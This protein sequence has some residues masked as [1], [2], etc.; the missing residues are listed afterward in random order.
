MLFS[1]STSSF[2]ESTTTT[3]SESSQHHH[4]HRSSISIITP[5]DEVDGAPTIG[6]KQFNR[7]N[8][9]EGECGCYLNEQWMLDINKNTTCTNCAFVSPHPSPSSPSLPINGMIRISNSNESSNSTGGV[10]VSFFNCTFV[11]TSVLITNIYNQSTTGT[12]SSNDG[13]SRGTTAAGISVSFDECQFSNITNEYVIDVQISNDDNDVKTGLNLS[14]NSVC[15]FFSFSLLNSRLTDNSMTGVRLYI[16]GVSERSDVDEDD[17]EHNEDLFVSTSILVFNTSFVGNQVAFQVVE[18]SLGMQILN[19]TFA[20]NYNV[21]VSTT[22]KYKQYYQWERYFTSAAISISQVYSLKGVTILSSVFES[23]SIPIG[24]G[25]AVSVFDSDF[26]LTIDDCIFRSNSVVGPVININDGRY[27]GGGVLY[28]EDLNMVITN[29]VFDDNYSAQFGGALLMSYSNSSRIS[30][31]TFNRNVGALGGAIGLVK[32]FYFS[33]LLEKTNQQEQQEPKQEQYS[34]SY[35][36]S[37]T[38]SSQSNTLITNC[39]FYQNVATIKGGAIFIALTAASIEYTQFLNNTAFYG[40]AVAVDDPSYAGSYFTEQTAAYITYSSFYNNAAEFSGGSIY[41]TVGYVFVGYTEIIDS[42]AEY[43]AG[44]YV[45]SQTKLVVHNTRVVLCSS[46]I[47][48]NKIHSGNGLLLYGGDASFYLTQFQTVEDEYGILS[49][50][51]AVTIS[52]ASFS[53]YK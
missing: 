40:G 42:L 34:D 19:S 31:C 44:F 36:A 41:F 23:N 13:D 52:G 26:T 8:R 22:N 27:N 18:S 4:K 24:F 1:F 16:R 51:V 10:F 30:N 46:F 39:T 7:S 28:V 47:C 15:D 6:G 33:E 20:H 29:S 2:V 38:D 45:A 25:G 11:R 3:A 43:G 12:Y 50:N 5:D 9:V 35:Y 37:G 53:C 32:L 48:T 14:S 21:N 17:R 49:P